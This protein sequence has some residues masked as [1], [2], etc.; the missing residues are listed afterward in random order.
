[1][2]EYMLLRRAYDSDKLPIYSKCTSI[3]RF[4]HLTLKRR[5]NKN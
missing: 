3:K 2:Y 4:E 1:M 5:Y